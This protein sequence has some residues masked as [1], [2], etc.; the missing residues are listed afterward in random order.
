[1]R[2]LGAELTGIAPGRVQITL[3]RRPEINLFF[4][5]CQAVARERS[6]GA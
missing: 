5:G 1:M 2:L 6:Y 4:G 3:A